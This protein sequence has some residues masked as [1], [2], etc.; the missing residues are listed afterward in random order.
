MLGRMFSWTEKTP[1]YRSAEPS[2]ACDSTGIVTRGFIAGTQVASN[3]G[4]RAV[5]ALAPGDMVLTF[6]NGMRPL[7]D[8]R[9]ETMWVDADY[10]PRA[11]WPV[12]VPEG[13]LGNRVA[14][15]LGADQGVMMES[16]LAEETFDD[17]FSV[18]RA[19]DLC[20]LRGIHRV[21]PRTRM[22]VV[23]LV[24][25]EEQVVHAEGGVLIHC[26]RPTVF[27][28]DMLAADPN[29][30]PVLTAELTALVIDEILTEDALAA[31]ISA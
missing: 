5:E 12:H 7:V 10:V 20:G 28:S 26:P 8:V 19:R 11:H 29:P 16:D 22:E 23:T 27:F 17:P 9:R 4:W 3:L 14:M 15:M 18:L 6:D 25:A 31:R 1:V 21:P 2:G 30:Y 13:A 24:F